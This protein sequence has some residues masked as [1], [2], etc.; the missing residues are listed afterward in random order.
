MQTTSVST[1][2]RKHNLFHTAR[3]PST[4][5]FVRHGPDRSALDTEE[6]PPL[7]ENEIRVSA[8]KSLVSVGTEITYLKGDGNF[9]RRPG[10]SG[11]SSVGRVTGVGASVKGFAMGDRVFCCTHHTSRYN[12]PGDKPG[13]RIPDGVTDTQATFAIL[14]SIAMHLVQRAEVNLG[15]PVVV[16]GLGSVGQLVA[17]F[18]RLSGAFVIAVDLDDE[19][20]E[21]ARRLSADAAIHPDDEALDR[22]LKEAVAGSAAPAF[23][24]ICG[25]SAAL[26]WCIEHAPLRSRVVAS[27]TFS[28]N[29]EFDPF[30]P[31]IKREIDV[32]GAHHPKCPDEPM[33]YYPYSKRFNVNYFFDAVARGVLNVDDLY[34]G[35]VTPDQAPGFFDAAVAGKPRLNQ[36]VIDWERQ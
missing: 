30:P 3:N 6:L 27:G 21:L 18:A 4:A 26:K 1:S 23:I 17:Q 31:F 13:Y 29:M 12:W 24:E 8:T 36:P 10:R 2:S 20:L 14:S 11:Y 32:V 19:R 34:D 25:S 5:S 16:V 28:S 22:A 35:T 15:R 7:K 33:I 9:A